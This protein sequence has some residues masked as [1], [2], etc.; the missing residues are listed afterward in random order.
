MKRQKGLKTSLL[1]LA[2]ILMG[3][4]VLGGLGGLAFQ[5]VITSSLNQTLNTFE[6]AMILSD[7]RGE[8]RQTRI[9]IRTVAVVGLS[10]GEALKKVDQ[11]LGHA[12]KVSELIAIYGKEYLV[13]SEQAVFERLKTNWKKFLD[14]GGSIV[15][16]TQAGIQENGPK[17]SHFILVDCP[18]AAGRVQDDLNELLSIQVKES[19]RTRAQAAQQSQQ[20][21]WV[22]LVFLMGSMVLGV[23]FSWSM[24]R[25]LLLES[26]KVSELIEA[27]AQEVKHVA[28]KLDQDSEALASLSTQQTETVKTILNTSREI[29]DVSIQNTTIAQKSLEIAD[30]S[31]EKSSEAQ[32]RVKDLDQ[33]LELLQQRAE[34]MR[35]TN[36][37][38]SEEIKKMIVL[39]TEIAD[40]TQV[41]HDIVFQ[42]KLLS[43]NA[44]VEAARAGE[45]GKGFA[46]V[47]EEVG[48]LAQKSGDAAKEISGL[49]ENSVRRA[50]EIIKSS[51]QRL[52]SAQSNTLAT[53][54]KSFEDAQRCAEVIREIVEKSKLTRQ[55]SDQILKASTDQFSGVKNIVHLLA[56]ID[57][58]TQ[59]NLAR[60]QQAREAT[61]NLNECAEHM[62]KGVEQLHALV[63]GLNKVA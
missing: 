51:S 26:K 11:A 8:F 28:Q 36:E 45:H 18:L 47:A 56:D 40:R 63:G 3:L 2:G 17:L 7:M 9:D 57:S 34:E 37:L 19:E 58:A 5:G 52:H 55:Q 31:L 54:Q 42:T 48:V 29:E 59:E 6:K 60:S 14:V 12:G 4:I 53:I 33:S 35:Q 32:E 21:K 20:S 24:M 38:N 43:F 44:S 15:Q 61:K 22:L 41:I 25:R 23:V 62:G 16:A 49:V 50:E 39:I 46:V 10:Q 13:P 30:E 1:L 27:G